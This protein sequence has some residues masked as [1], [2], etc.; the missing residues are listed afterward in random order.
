MIMAEPVDNTAIGKLNN[1]DELKDIKLWVRINIPRY[2][3]V[4]E[5]EVATAVLTAANS[6]NE[7]MKITAKDILGVQ[8]LSCSARPFW[9]INLSSKKT[10][11]C[12]LAAANIE[13]KERSFQISEYATPQVRR[14]KRSNNI[15]LSIHGIPQNI[16]D[17]EVESWVSSF[18]TLASPIFRHTSKD[19]GE[20]NEFSHLLTGHRY[21]FVSTI[22]EDKPRYSSMDIPDPLDSQK[23]I[24]IE[25]VLY[26][27]GQ[28]VNCRYCHESGHLISA[29]PNKPQVKCFHCGTVGHVKQRCPNLGKGPKCF[30]CNNYGH[31]SYECQATP[32][33][34]ENRS[35]S[36]PPSVAGGERFAKASELAQEL[37]DHCLNPNSSKS[38]ELLGKVKALLNFDEVQ[39][40]TGCAEEP[41]ATSQMAKKQNKLKKKG[42]KSK[43]VKA[44]KTN[45]TPP[46]QSVPG[47]SKTRQSSMMDFGKPKAASST[48]KRKH[49][50]PATE[51]LPEKRDRRE[52]SVEEEV[53]QDS[54]VANNVQK[55]SVTGEH[56]PVE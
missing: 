16:A 9:I 50:S 32:K 1:N 41:A 51:K 20:N 8:H 33:R 5:T 39:E 19:K 18:A 24:D 2:I 12:V 55:R 36:T 22:L 38:P 17:A 13:L 25:V 6:V 34:T 43:N 3:R 15:R 7:N 31:K 14:N 26:Y 4:S 37:I 29:C 46:P 11:A 42:D 56:S 28:P 52:L 48:C 45:P 10:K 27:T 21:C 54:H 23:L 35:Q 30:K 53:G 47:T 44:K 49:L 40:E